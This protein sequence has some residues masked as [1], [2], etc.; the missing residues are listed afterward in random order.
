MLGEPP[1]TSTSPPGHFSRPGATS[2]Q[3]STILSE[4]LAAASADT[5]W[6]SGE[7]MWSENGTRTRSDRNPPQ[8]PPNEP[9]PY[10]ERNGTLSQ[11]PVSPRRQRTHSPHES[12][13]GTLTR[14]PC[15]G[16]PSGPSTT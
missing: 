1:A 16:P 14:V 5:P 6:G 13:N 2:R 15:S 10:M 7:S 3:P 9:N 4:T 8:S 11:L 12:W